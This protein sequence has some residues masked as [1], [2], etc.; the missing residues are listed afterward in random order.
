MRMGEDL[1]WHRVDSHSNLP[2]NPFKHFLLTLSIPFARISLT[3]MKKYQHSLNKVE[4]PFNAF[5]SMILFSINF[6]F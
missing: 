3:L 5:K 4:F 6:L 2:H 1:M